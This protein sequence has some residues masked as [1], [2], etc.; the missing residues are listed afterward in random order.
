MLFKPIMW[1]WLSLS[2]SPPSL[3][4]H[5]IVSVVGDLQN[6]PP[7]LL[8]RFLREHRSEWADYGV[9]AYSAACLK[10]SPYAVPCARPGGFPGSQV[11]LPLAHTVEN[12]EVTILSST[13]K[14]FPR[15]F[16]S[17]VYIFAPF[18]NTNLCKILSFIL[19]KFLEVVR[20]EGHAFSPE[21]VALARDMYLLQVS[22]FI[23]VIWYI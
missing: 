19:M 8:V 7:A 1:G 6:V 3:W 10:A 18:S 5:F 12:E 15:S 16:F 23:T 13:L 21:D 9:D 17:L 14:L 22:L 20:L 11:I 4:H 2:G